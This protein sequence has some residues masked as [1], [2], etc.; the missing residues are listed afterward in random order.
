I[1]D[2][3]LHLDWSALGA[4]RDT[5]AI[6]SAQLDD[7]DYLFN[8]RVLVGLVTRDLL[9][10]SDPWSGRLDRYAALQTQAD[11]QTVAVFAE[12]LETTR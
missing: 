12:P 9:L 2:G 5:V 3:R 10:V 7:A 4:E 6:P 1:R 11:Y 8:S